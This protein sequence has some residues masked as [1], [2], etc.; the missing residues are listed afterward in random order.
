MT[1]KQETAT[2]EP[3]APDQGGAV[4]L[5]QQAVEVFESML[6]AIPEGGDDA[7]ERIL[8]Q[9]ANAADVRDLDAPWRSDGMRDYANQPLVITEV[10]R[11]PS[12]FTAGVGWFLVV[13]AATRDGVLHTI[14]TGAV[15]IVG[16]L[17]KAYNLDALP[18]RCI[19]RVA[20]RPTRRG[21]FPMHL[22]ILS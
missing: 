2:Q 22:E 1:D 17:V 7:W 6:G 15:G 5:S 21:Y 10:K 20:D 8:G 4:V 9:L 18:L 11:S 14:T 16:Q 19:P 12:A 13:Q 3:A